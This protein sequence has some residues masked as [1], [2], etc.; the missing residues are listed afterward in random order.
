MWLFENYKKNNKVRILRICG[1]VVYSVTKDYK[2]KIERFFG[3]I[4]S[5]SK[6]ERNNVITKN[7]RVFN[8]VISKRIVDENYKQEYLFNRLIKQTDLKQKFM[9]EY[10]KY[11]KEYSDIFI[12]NASSGETYLFLTY[13]FDAFIKKN[14]CEKT[15]LVA[16]KKYHVDLIKMLCPELPYIYQKKC[17]KFNNTH[18][19]IN[20]KNFYMFFTR[21]HFVQVEEKIKNNPLYSVHYFQEI[22]NNLEIS[23]SELNFRKIQIPK[24]IEKSML[25]KISK[26]NLNLDNFVFVAPEAASCEEYDNKFWVDLTNEFKKNGIDVFM[27]IVNKNTNIHGCDY[28]TSILGFAETFALAKKAKAVITL[29][30][31]LTECLL[32]TNVPLFSLYTKFRNRC[33]LKSMSLEFVLSGFSLNKLPNIKQE[34]LYEYNMAEIQSPII[35]SEILKT[36][37]RVND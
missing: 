34:L 22:L 18:T 36:E 19:K 33:V 37:M 13:V 12:L 30:S 16:T 28:K 24:E 17:K 20:G 26:T 2:R 3:N 7:I 9:K 11:F 4:L 32:Q 6:T 31:G 35:V 10:D 8:K 21:N 1:N 15:L 5:T 23:R 14:N 27:N 29:R 25:N